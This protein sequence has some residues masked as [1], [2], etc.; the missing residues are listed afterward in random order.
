MTAR[1]SCLSRLVR[2]C[3]NGELFDTLEGG[4][5]T[6]DFVA[7]L[8][9]LGEHVFIFDERTR[10]DRTAAVLGPALLSRLRRDAGSPRTVEGIALAR[11]MSAVSDLRAE[12]VR[13]HDRL[14][15]LE[16]LLQAAVE[17]DA[18]NHAKPG[19]TG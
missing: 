10:E 17:R 19:A 4:P 3:S 1:E 11:A 18:A 16:H 14:T 6:L 12:F 9:W 5:V 13:M 7:D 15:G 8:V 2:R